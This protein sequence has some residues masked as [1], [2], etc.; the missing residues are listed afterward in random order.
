MSRQTTAEKDL[1]RVVGTPGP[2]EDAKGK[3][4]TPQPQ[5]RSQSSLLTGDKVNKNLTLPSPEKVKFEKKVIEDLTT[6][7]APQEVKD[8]LTLDES[9]RLGLTA[10]ILR[11]RLN[12][13]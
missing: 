7:I 6:N 12:P 9:R 5:Q 2:Q 3:L 11:R 4:T 8:P 13:N 1:T 10:R